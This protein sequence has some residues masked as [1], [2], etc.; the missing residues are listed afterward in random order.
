MTTT[1]ASYAS[2]LS[3]PRDLRAPTQRA[4]AAATDGLHQRGTVPHEWRHGRC[5]GCAMRESWEGARH[6]CSNPQPVTV[7][8]CG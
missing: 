4:R 5:L 1:T 6:A 3:A 2:A 7:R 8:G